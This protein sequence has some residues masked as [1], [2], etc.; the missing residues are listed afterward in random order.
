MDKE[1]KRFLKKIGAVKKRTLNYAETRKMW[2][3]LQL[4]EPDDGWTDQRVWTEVY[5]YEGLEYHVHRTYDKEIV[6]EILE[7]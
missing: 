6:I 3:I 4:M 1:F 2:A 7:E 5:I